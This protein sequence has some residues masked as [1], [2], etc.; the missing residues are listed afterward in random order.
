ML[1]ELAPPADHLGIW[2]LISTTKGTP[3]VL[4][5]SALIQSFHLKFYKEKDNEWNLFYQA[6]CFRRCHAC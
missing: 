2:Y 3:E 4:P 1:A 6:P 5:W